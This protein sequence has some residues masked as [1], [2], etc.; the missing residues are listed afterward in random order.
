MYVRAKSEVYPG[1]NTALNIKI[2]NPE[3]HRLASEPARLR[4]VSVSRAVMDAVQHEL[5]R[6]KDRRNTALKDRLL[7]IGK[8]A[9][10][11]AR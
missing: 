3:V 11:I 5:A 1:R 9:R 10:R 8:A 2:K 7:A 6:E 4:D